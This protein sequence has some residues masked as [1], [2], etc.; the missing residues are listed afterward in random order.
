MV[1]CRAKF[2]DLL[3]KALLEFH[4]ES[5]FG[6]RVSFHL[7]E[8]DSIK[9]YQIRLQGNRQNINRLS[10]AVVHICSL[11]RITHWVNVL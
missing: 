9:Y 2:V 5:V 11:L 4:F 6:I 8:D 10:E 1:T 7:T 3:N